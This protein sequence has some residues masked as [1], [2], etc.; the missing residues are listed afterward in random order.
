MSRVGGSAPLEV[1][2]KS[3][4]YSSAAGRTREALGE[5]AFALEIGKVG[6]IVGPSGCGKTTLLRII[7]GLD[8][9][10]EG[11]VALP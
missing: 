8:A 9:R 11:F 6:A 2:I 7:A 10:F 4:A 1:A 5:L 3:K